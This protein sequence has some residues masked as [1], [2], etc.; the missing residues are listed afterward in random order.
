M[1]GLGVAVFSLSILVMT[2]PML[3]RYYDSLRNFTFSCVLA[4]ALVIANSIYCLYAI[5]RTLSVLHYF[6]SIGQLLFSLMT[7][8]SSPVFCRI[9]AV[10]FLQCLSRFWSL[11]QRYPS[12]LNCAW[13]GPH[14]ILKI[15]FKGQRKCREGFYFFQ[16]RLL[17]IQLFFCQF[18]SCPSGHFFYFYPLP[19]LS[20]VVL[21]EKGTPPALRSNNILELYLHQDY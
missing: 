19:S 5:I 21:F 13:Y 9:L 17:V 3:E 12:T 4:S 11:P 8:G 18:F 15:R 2:K 1:Q 6:V 10:I 16:F 7:R 14:F 20:F